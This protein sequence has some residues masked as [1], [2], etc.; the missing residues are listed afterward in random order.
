MS[1]STCFTYSCAALVGLAV[2]IGS[3]RAD[4]VVGIH[5][6]VC[7]VPYGGEGGYGDG[8]GGSFV[9]DDLDFFL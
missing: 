8:H 2:A 5:V 3:V 6:H 4:D 1:V 7:E 9:D